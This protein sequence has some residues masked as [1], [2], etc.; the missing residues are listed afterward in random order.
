MFISFQI[1]L[2]PKV[3]KTKDNTQRMMP[4]IK[5]ILCWG[6]TTCQ[7][8]WVIL[9]CLPHQEKRDRRGSRGD[10]RKGQG[11]KRKRNE[12]EETGETRNVSI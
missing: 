4:D 5:F 1:L 3:G 9:C 11:R 7:P 12:S 10:E 8:L 6:L 2:L